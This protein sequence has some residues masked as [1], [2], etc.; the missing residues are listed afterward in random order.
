MKS[1]RT[2]RKIAKFFGGSKREQILIRLNF[3]I[4]QMFEQKRLPLK[5][6]VNGQFRIRGKSGHVNNDSVNE[7]VIFSNKIH[8]SPYLNGL[9]DGEKTK[10][11]YSAVVTPGLKNPRKIRPED[12]LSIL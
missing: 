4:I 8:Q 10:S 5:E 6:K 9:S 2:G 3:L 7:K 11:I 12:V 1:N